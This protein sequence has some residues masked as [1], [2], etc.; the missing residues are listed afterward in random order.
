MFQKMI[1]SPSCM[2][3]FNARTESDRHLW[4]GVIGTDWVGKCNDNGFKLLSMCAEHELLLTNTVFQLLNKLRGT[5]MHQRS[6][7]WHVQDYIITRQRHKSETL[8]TRVMVGADDCWTDHR[9][10]VSKLRPLIKYATHNRYQKPVRRLNVR[11]AESS[12]RGEAYRRMTGERLREIS[13]NGITIDERGM[14]IRDVIHTSAVERLG[15]EKKQNQDWLMRMI[16][17]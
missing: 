6:K 7:H 5:W 15:Y 9:L 2:G 12:G 10:L 17:T 11:A 4:P 1:D 3:D 13:I 14:E 16:L 8:K